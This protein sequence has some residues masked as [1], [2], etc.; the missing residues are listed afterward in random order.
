MEGIS[1][2]TKTKVKF[3][4]GYNKSENF[5]HNDTKTF[6]MS[7][8]F[9]FSGYIW[10]TEL[11]K[12]S[13][14]VYELK[15]RHPVFTAVTDRCPSSPLRAPCRLQKGENQVTDAQ[16]VHLDIFIPKTKIQHYSLYCYLHLWYLGTGNATAV[17]SVL[18]TSS[19]CI[20]PN[21]TFYCY[22]S[23]LTV[24]YS[25]LHGG[26]N[27]IHSHYQS[28]IAP[29]QHSKT[30]PQREIFPYGNHYVVSKSQVLL[31]T[32]ASTQGHETMKQCN[33]GK[34]NYAPEND[35]PKRKLTIY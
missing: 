29:D 2:P 31:A 11:D 16:G 14:H 9:S 12:Y 7:K 19:H 5:F 24:S 21:L 10:L 23:A 4:T 22:Y 18:G 27:F 15:T 35:T 3:T 28:H 33:A 17:C 30:H 6:W 8:H 20:L 34:Y 32:Y 26:S 13:F 1:I 25:L